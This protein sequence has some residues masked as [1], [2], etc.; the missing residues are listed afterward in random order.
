MAYRNK[1]S[2]KLYLTT[3]LQTTINT[4]D[5]TAAN[6]FRFKTE[7]FDTPVPEPD[8]MADAGEVGDGVGYA[9]NIWN[10]RWKPLALSL[11]GMINDVLFPKLFARVLGGTVVDTV[12][13]ASTS[14]DHTIPMATELELV[15]PKISTLITE[16]APQFIWGDVFVRGLT[17]TQD[18][19]GMPH[20]SAEL[21]NT[22]HWKKLSDSSIVVSSVPA[23]NSDYFGAR[24]HGAATTLVYNNGGS[25]DLT[26]NRG[27]C[28]VTAKLTQP[29]NVANLPG[30][31]FYVAGDST[32]GS[33]S[34]TIQRTTQEADIIQF[35][36]Y[37]DT[38]LAQ[39]ADEKAGTVLTNVILKF[40][41]KVIGAST[42]KYETEIKLTR[43]QVTVT[44]PTS[45]D[46]YE[47]FDVT[48]TALPDTT[49]KR[50]CVGRHR[51]G[52]ATLV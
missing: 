47:A 24:Y 18:G 16:G 10:Y 34:A 44:K 46:E 6:Y 48:I 11:S 30:D 14:W 8:Q 9:Q 33:Y 39:W 21:G 25:I 51:N 27:L 13:T 12:V 40:Q 32:S 35:R 49:T 42:D 52:T 38:T 2:V 1:K 3:G 4:P 15:Q 31:A 19:D 36:V 17:I 41:G 5:E 43:G 50:L 28:S 45:K 37:A 29:A 20:W 22:G 7:P 23:L 26:A